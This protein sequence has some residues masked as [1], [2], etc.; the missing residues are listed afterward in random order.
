MGYDVGFKKSK[1]AVEEMHSDALARKV[2]FKEKKADAEN[3]RSPTPVYDVGFEKGK[4]A[5]E[6]V[7]DGREVHEED[8][9][10]DKGQIKDDKEQKE[11]DADQESHEATEDGD[12]PQ[13]DNEDLEQRLAKEKQLQDISDQFEKNIF[14]D[15]APMRDVEDPKDEGK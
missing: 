8:N 13:S 12:A 7:F 4:D 15:E 1:D 3:R 11:K 10:D 9:K 5:V 2:D 6:D 14:K